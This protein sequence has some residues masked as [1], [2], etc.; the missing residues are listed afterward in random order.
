MRNQYNNRYTAGRDR[1]GSHRDLASG[2]TVTVAN[3]KL[4]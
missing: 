2:E 4:C 1:H 3:N